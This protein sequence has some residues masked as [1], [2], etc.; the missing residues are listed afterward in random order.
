MSRRIF[1]LLASLG[2][3]IAVFAVA[4]S[5]GTDSDD[6]TQRG[7]TQLPEPDDVIDEPLMLALSR[8]K[9]F[10]HIANVYLQDGNTDAAIA[11]VGKILRIE[12]PA[13]APEAQ[14]VLLDARARLGKLLLGQGKQDEALRVVDEGIASAHRDSYFLANLY[15]VRG[16]ILETSAPN[17]E[18]EDEAKQRRRDAIEAF[19]TSNEMQLKIMRA[20]AKELGQ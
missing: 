12:F 18:T 9:N 14:D 5:C 7:V 6:G 15:T 4:T 3:L 13:G 20:L 11:E 17:G 8:A 19:E 10:H 16:E 2:L 1:A